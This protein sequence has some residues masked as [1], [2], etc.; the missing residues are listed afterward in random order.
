MRVSIANCG[1]ALK[2]CE[3]RTEKAGLFCWSLLALLESSKNKLSYLPELFC[4]YERSLTD[5]A[6]PY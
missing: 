1:L 5:S 6:Y 3:I 2:L 4:G